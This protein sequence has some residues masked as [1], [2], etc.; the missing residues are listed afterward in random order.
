MQLLRYHLR[1]VMWLMVVLGLAIAW[2]VDHER[3]RWK[4]TDG[5]LWIPLVQLTEG[6]VVREISRILDDADISHAIRDVPHGGVR[7]LVTLPNM[8]A[9]SAAIA[10]HP[11]LARVQRG[12]PR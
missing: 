7:I 3:L 10:D 6:H 2:R 9:A 1:D 4:P 11:A 5:E 8:D 12:K